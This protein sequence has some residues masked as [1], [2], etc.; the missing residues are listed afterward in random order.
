MIFKSQSGTVTDCMLLS[1]VLQI[2][3]SVIAV[4][5]HYFFLAAFS[6]MCLEGIQ[7]YMMLIEVFEAEKSR[8]KY[9][10]LAAYGE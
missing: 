6:W 2:L 10:Y 8:V 9:Y 3:C 5:L 7:L 1:V 4:L